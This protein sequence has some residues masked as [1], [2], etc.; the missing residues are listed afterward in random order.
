MYMANERR[1][2][3]LRLLE[4]RGRLR[5][6]TLAAELGVT[7]ETIR[8]D[9]VL[10]QKQGLLKRVHGGAVYQPPSAR[11]GD[12]DAERLDMR[13]CTPLAERLSAGMRL[14]GDSTP[15]FFALAL[16][17][18][19]KPCTIICAS[20]K[21][22]LVLAAHHLPHKVICP[23]GTFDSE[24]RLLIPPRLPETLH[25]LRPD[26]ALLFPDAL[27]PQG[28]AYR[29]QARMQWARA[30]AAA[31]PQTLIAAPSA[32][33]SL[34]TDHHLSLCADL[35]VTEAPAGSEAPATPARKRL[36]LPRPEPPMPDSEEAAG[37]G[38]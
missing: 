10:M 9:F 32:G 16:L 4:E 19:D 38:R 15:L 24:S 11:P 34:E 17:L 8:T 28:V 6:A 18:R 12:A 14:I 31:A 1:R 25:Q 7:D 20:P 27:T 35:L 37:W 30:A 22:I 33:H 5:S 29:Q 2:Y 36:I 21:L 23:G 13:L 26:I 3:I